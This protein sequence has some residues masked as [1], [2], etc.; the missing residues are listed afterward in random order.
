MIKRAIILLAI[1]MVAAIVALT[2][3]KNFS[4]SSIVLT[5][6]PLL[7]K[8]KHDTTIVDR[9][10]TNTDQV[11]I[12]LINCRN[13][14]IRNCRLSF[15]KDIA[16]SIYKCHNITIDHCYMESVAT[17][18]YALESQGIKVLSSHAKNMRGPFP[19]GQ[20]V[21]F[22]NV[23]GGG[24]RVSFNVCENILGLSYPEDI[25]N[26]Y[27][28]NGTPAD[29]VQITGNK[30]RGGGPSKSGGGIMLGDR[31]GS[32]ITA[33]KNILVNPGQYGMAIAGGTHMQINNNIIYGKKQY[34]TNV[35]LY[36]WNQS[37]GAC[38]LNTIS[39]NSVN[40]INADGEKHSCWNQGNCGP[41]IG[42]GTNNWSAAINEGLLPAVLFNK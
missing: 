25:I 22:D 14:T 10:I 9:V 42:W 7:L 11:C 21:Q 8:D 18:V 34:F 19:R 20:M 33:T 23:Y 41:V 29:P 40:W 15:S 4:K 13:I 12:K 30:I 32:Y 27:Q 28:T 16:I 3:L 38:A 1:L 26:M 36:I 6:A 24:N 17:G 5:S 39:N 37:P 31:G 2:Y 35:G